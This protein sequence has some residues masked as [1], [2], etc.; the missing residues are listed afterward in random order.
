MTDETQAEEGLF[1]AP[2]FYKATTCDLML[3]HEHRG[4]AEVMHAQN[5]VAR[6]LL[7]SR[8]RN[9]FLRCHAGLGVEQSSTLWVY[10]RNTLISVERSR[11]SDVARRSGIQRPRREEFQFFV[12][13]CTKRFPLSQQGQGQTDRRDCET[14]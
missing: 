14:S 2:P 7:H 13:V 12:C 1:L 5:V 3:L 6:V 9:N 8:C 10:D 11:S 4:A